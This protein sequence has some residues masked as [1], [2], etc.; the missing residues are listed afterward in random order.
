M[1]N[2]APSYIIDNGQCLTEPQE[3]ANALNKYSVNV[4][5][6]IQSPI[7]YSKNNV[8]NF[9]P[10][11]N[12]NSFFLNLTDEIE[13]K[14]I[15]LSLNPSKTTR[16]NSIPT[17]ILN[18]LINDVWSQLTDIFNLPFSCGVFPLIR[19]PHTSLKKDSKLKCSGVLIT[20]QYPYYEILTKHSK[21]LC[22]NANIIF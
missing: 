20:G 15:I 2:V 8:H 21:D 14:N 6:D 16:P 4:A 1:P 3:I 9:L 17:K 11:L 7:R 22:T 10:H 19:K 5:T 13:V 12:I 18:L